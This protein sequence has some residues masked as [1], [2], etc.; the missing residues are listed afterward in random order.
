MKK[1]FLLFIGCL[2]FCACEPVDFTSYLN[3]EP[4]N[5]YPMYTFPAVDS[6]DQP[7]SFHL[8]R[9]I[10]FA[11]KGGTETYLSTPGYSKRLLVIATVGA[12]WEKTHT[13][14]PYFDQLARE[15]KDTELEF[16]LLFVDYDRELIA[17]L[18]EVQTLQYAHA[19]YNAP[20]RCENE[21]GLCS[22]VLEVFS[23]SSPQLH[24]I[25]KDKAFLYPGYS[26][27]PD[28][29]DEA[30]LEEAYQGIRK[31][32]QGFLNKFGPNAAEN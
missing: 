17:S 1:L 23:M 19:F 18:P 32:V 8:I 7:L 16:A 20:S 3:T 28:T 22:Y 15:F 24:Y 10:D 26:A 31:H 4:D 27:W 29:E 9:Q 6:E 5:P 2:A 12:T 21:Y 30:K 25:A 11:N 13:Y 14:L